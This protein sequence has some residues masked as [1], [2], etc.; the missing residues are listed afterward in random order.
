MAKDQL[1]IFGNILDQPKKKTDNLELGSLKKLLLDHFKCSDI[2]VFFEKL[3]YAYKNNDRQFYIDLKNLVGNIDQDWLQKIYQYYGADRK[4]LKQDYTPK[5]LAQLTAKLAIREDG[6]K[7]L[8]CCCGTGALTIQASQLFEKS[9]FECLE[10]DTN[11]LPFLKANLEMRGIIY[12][13]K[14]YNVIDDCNLAGNTEDCA[15]VCDYCISNP[16]FNVKWKHPLFASSLPRFSLCLPP[17]QNAN[18]VFV[19]TAM[20]HTSKVGAFI[21]P[22]SITISDF[23]K[24][25]R[26]ALVNA[27]VIEAVI[28][29]PSDMFESTSIPTSILV[30]NKS[31]KSRKTC[32][33]KIENLCKQEECEQVGQFGGNS[34]TNRIYKKK[35][36]VIPDDIQDKVLKTVLEMKDEKG[37]SK[38]VD[39]DIIKS[40]DYSLSPSQYVESEKIFKVERRSYESI[41]ADLNAVTREKNKLK[42]TINENAARCFGN[43]FFMAVSQIEKSNENM[44]EIAN[45]LKSFGI[46]VK[47][48]IA[49]CVKVSKD[50]NVIRIEQNTDDDGISHILIKLITAWTEHFYYLNN[51]ENKI[52]AELRDK[53]LED[54]MKS[55]I[56][57]NL[58]NL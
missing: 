3:A 53:T 19:L 6:C 17:E 22:N 9:S 18:Y 51:L 48:D 39:I 16:P 49:D 37:F 46:D 52:L 31:K 58:K 27:N 35:F 28:S 44:R 43:N 4:N 24:E 7:V 34:H 8:D 45:G 54:I 10:L 15:F 14:N 33:I 21:L 36:N 26:K 47:I 41:V 50:K 38:C 1:D 12:S 20:S 5:T 42:I 55:A 2:K 40:S 13:V 29:C 56:T 32:F 23:E 30:V 57:K 25:V 11:V